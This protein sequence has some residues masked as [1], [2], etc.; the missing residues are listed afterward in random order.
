MK[1]TVGLISSVDTAMNK[2]V[3]HFKTMLCDSILNF[4][5]DILGNCYCDDFTNCWVIDC[6]LSLTLITAK[7]G[8]IL[9]KTVSKI[10]IYAQELTSW[11]V[12]FM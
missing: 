7:W 6:Q 2:N 8:G 9:S 10:I 12:D 5:L 3:I 4:N 1:Q 11:E